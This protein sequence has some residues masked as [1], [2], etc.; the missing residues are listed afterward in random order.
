[1]FQP[2]IKWSGSKRSQANEIITYFPKEIDIYYEPFC[3]GAS[4]LRTLLESDIKVN[5]YV[6]SDINRDLINLWNEIKLN[7]IGISEVYKKRWHELN[8]KDDDKE[9]KKRY[10]EYVRE[11]YNREHKPYDFF[12][13][14]RTCFN[15]L[16]RYNENG[17]FNSPYHLNR[18]GIKP[19]KIKSIL[20]EWSKLLIDN[21]VKFFHSDYKQICPDIKDFMYLDPP[22]SATKGMYKGNFNR[23]DFFK[24]LSDKD[25]K[26]VLSYDG[27]S[28]NV[29]NT[30]DVPENLYD[31]HVYIKSGNSS[32][33]RLKES[34]KNAVVFESLYVKK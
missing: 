23:N 25:C 9:R 13:I 27:I 19:E 10:F 12:F 28:G 22:Y 20:L 33:K 30:F 24:W 11:L 21:D 16:I 18:N 5:T 6:C 26:W 29:N 4:V 1:M 14:L 31:E 32:F 8:D 3:G 2:A 15:G 17:Q 7:P 34:D